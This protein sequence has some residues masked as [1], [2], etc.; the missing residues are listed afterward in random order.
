MLLKCHLVWSIKH[1]RS[2]PEFVNRLRSPGIDSLESMPG[3]LKRHLVWS[4]K[5]FRSEPEF[6]NRLSSPGI[7][8]LESM[9]G[10]LKL[11]KYGLS[12]LIGRLHVRIQW[13]RSFLNGNEI[14][15]LIDKICF[16]FFE[17]FH[18]RLSFKFLNSATKQKIFLWTW[19]WI[20]LYFPFPVQH[21]QVV[22]IVAA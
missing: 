15:R 1:F 13:F 7:D 16:S 8:S 17:L 12:T 5:R 6:V 3:L 20:N 14:L 2:E 18:S 21:N 4:I 10:L 19:I 11:Y 22:E 9:P